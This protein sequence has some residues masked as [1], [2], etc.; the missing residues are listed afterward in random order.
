MSSSTIGMDRS[1]WG[2]T[3]TLNSTQLGAVDTSHMGEGGG[4]SDLI[5]EGDLPGVP[6][7]NACGEQPLHVTQEDHSVYAVVLTTGLLVETDGMKPSFT[8]GDSCS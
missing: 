2:E 6:T 1:S 8:T 5:P 7:G 3:H 4:L